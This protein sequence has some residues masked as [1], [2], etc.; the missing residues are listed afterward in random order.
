MF[1]A[2][3]T[4][5]ETQTSTKETKVS[6]REQILNHL[7]ANPKATR[8]EIAAL[9]GT[10]EQYVSIVRTHAG[11]K[12]SKPGRKNSVLK[13]NAPMPAVSHRDVELNGLREA[14]RVRDAVIGELRGSE[15]KLRQEINELT[16]IIAYLEH[17]C[18]RA[19]GS[20]GVAV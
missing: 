18:A 2:N 15:E 19:E 6:K 8:K 7:E 14:V 4:A 17:R 13:N 16:I 9:L 5:P 12:K 1:E 10:T 11:F 3:Q 20:R